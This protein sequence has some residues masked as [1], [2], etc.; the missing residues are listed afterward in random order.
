MTEQR[1][2]YRFGP[3]ERRGLLGPLRLGQAILVGFA[4]ATGVELLDQVGGGAGVGEIVVVRRLARERKTKR[5]HRGA[6]GGGDQCNPDKAARH[7]AENGQFGDVLREAPQERQEHHQRYQ[8]R[9]EGGA[10][11]FHG[12]GETHRVFLH[13]LRGA[14]GRAD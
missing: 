8:R 9:E 4:L 7:G 10:Q 2:S 14:F 11:I 12:V 3:L 6:Q 13:T 1:L 5:Q